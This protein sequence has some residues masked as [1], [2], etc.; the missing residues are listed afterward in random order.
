VTIVKVQRPI[1]TNIAERPWLIYDQYDAR[2]CFI[3]EKDLPPNI[4][5]V[6]NSRPRE[7]QRNRSY[8]KDAEW[9]KAKEVWDLSKCV[10]TE[11]KKW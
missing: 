5:L 7:Y 6:M 4:I 3:L 11:D 1:T 8:F 9:D 10:L 2:R